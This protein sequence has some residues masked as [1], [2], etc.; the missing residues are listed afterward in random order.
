MGK[1][2]VLDR[3]TGPPAALSLLATE[4]AGI[5]KQLEPDFVR[6]T[7][8]LMSLNARAGELSALGSRLGEQVGE[9]LEAIRRD[10]VGTLLAG[11]YA[12]LQQSLLDSTTRCEGLAANSRV[13]DALQ[14]LGQRIKDIATRLAV[15]RLGF[16]IECARLGDEAHSFIDFVAQLTELEQLVAQLGDAV[17]SEAAAARTTL[18]RSI[19]LVRD[20]LSGLQ[21]LMQRCSST[22]SSAA[23]SIDGLLSVC[24]QVGADVAAG[25]REI[26]AHCGELVYFLQFGD[27]VR[28]KIEHVAGALANAGDAD[29]TRTDRLLALQAGQIEAI[30]SDVGDARTKLDAAFGGLGAATGSLLSV[31][32]GFGS[33]AGSVSLTKLIDDVRSMQKLRQQAQQLSESSALAAVDASQVAGRLTRHLDT[34]TATN[35]RMHM[36]ALNAVVNTARL[37][38]A[39]AAL[40]VLSIEVHEISR[41]SGEI[42]A[43]VL[44]LLEQVQTSASAMIAHDAARVRTQACDSIASIERGL[45]RLAELIDRVSSVTTV[46]NRLADG[47]RLALETARRQI[48]FLAGFGDDMQG[49]VARLEAM[50]AAL[51]PIEA[52]AQRANDDEPVF[53]TY[54]MESEREV[55]RRVLGGGANV[56]SAARFAASTRGTGGNDLG[57]NVELF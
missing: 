54:T 28:Q 15:M 20:G 18:G 2:Q 53:A 44:P 23:A 24:G 7:E 37:G 36:M 31:I 52:S 39:A 3:G 4:L 13:M 41:Q 30:A 5:G 38:T 32:A 47:Q 27:I 40:S 51:G 55:H 33:G 42:V 22:A 46:A 10:E 8:G 14:H 17:R 26:G 6:L 25:A 12:S 34:I 19:A 56:A 57:D 21:H 16:S 29:G 50:R 9:Q 35:S 49:A 48:N 1:S 45:G 11:S 43:E